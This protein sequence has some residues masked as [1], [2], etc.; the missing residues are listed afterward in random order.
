MKVYAVKKRGGLGGADVEALIYDGFGP[1]YASGYAALNFRV[2]EVP[3][4][5]VSV[6]GASVGGRS[7]SNAVQVPP[8][9]PEVT[10]LAFRAAPPPPFTY[11][12]VGSAPINVYQ[13][14]QNNTTSSQ[15]FTVADGAA[16]RYAVTVQIQYAATGGYGS[17]RHTLTLERGGVTLFTGYMERDSNPD[18][19]VS[20]EIDLEPGEYTYTYTY[21]GGAGEPSTF[22]SNSTHLTLT[23]FVDPDPD[24]VDR[25]PYEFGYQTPYRSASVYSGDVW[26][27]AVPAHGPNPT[28]AT[29][30]DNTGRTWVHAPAKA[31]ADLALLE[32]N[33]TKTGETLTVY[34]AHIQSDNANNYRYTLTPL[35]P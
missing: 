32:F 28:Q 34:M 25:S 29:M 33:T 2:T 15:A 30:T 23:P 22:E 26:Q 11:P 19:L 20:G 31:A 4:L 21:A 3:A 1:F 18:M 35:T 27:Q 10:P 24:P 7:A 6:L 9:E 14:T 17:G 13:G 5:M 16:G 8:P 12:E